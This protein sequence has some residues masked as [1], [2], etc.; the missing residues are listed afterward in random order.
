METTSTTAAHGLQLVLRSAQSLS[1]ILAVLTCAAL[2]RVGARVF[3]F[4][5][6]VSSFVSLVS[7][8]T[9]VVVTQRRVWTPSRRVTC[10]VEGTL[11]VLWTAALV[12]VATTLFDGEPNS[13]WLFLSV[14]VLAVGVVIQTTLLTLVASRHE[15]EGA[16][17]TEVGREDG[18]VRP[19]PATTSCYTSV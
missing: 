12:A 3:L 17:P 8:A 15:G 2:A 19:V 13:P 14:F 18:L 10:A 5:L 11:L 9:L 7:V 16:K 6:F 1:A 4:S